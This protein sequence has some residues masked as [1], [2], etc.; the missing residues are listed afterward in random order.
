M[1][2][3]LVGGGHSTAF[4]KSS[5]SFNGT[6]SYVDLGTTAF[7]IERTQA[8]TI[9]VWVKPSAT[10]GY[11]F[12]NRNPANNYIGIGFGIKTNGHL[13]ANLCGAST[14]MQVDSL[15]PVQGIWSMV[16]WTNDGELWRRRPETLCQ[17]Y[18][19]N[20]TR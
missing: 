9:N 8:F 14:T 17:R 7:A 15:G 20:Q 11:F 12:T 5:G 16:T 2:R 6:T 18:P 4:D 10:N 13:F 3:G 19:S 1:L